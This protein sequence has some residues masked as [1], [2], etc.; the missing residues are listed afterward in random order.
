MG[1]PLIKLAFLAVKQVA[2]PIATRVKT[3]AREN[4][5]FRSTIIATGR[6]LHFGSVGIEHY[7]DGAS[8]RQVRQMLRGLA[9]PPEAKALE[10]GTDF[11]AEMVVYS[12]SASIIG[13]EYYMSEKKAAKTAAAKAA[14]VAEV[15]RLKEL[16]EELQWQ[17]VRQLH[18]I[19]SDVRYRLQKLEERRWW[20]WAR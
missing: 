15:L 17:E 9:D 7:A 5:L 18:L 3:S 13:A 20:S 8:L 2:K 16:N 11:V 12:V 14:R 4:P 1:L 19:L 10:R 6:R